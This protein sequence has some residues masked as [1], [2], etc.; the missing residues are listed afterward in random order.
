MAGK[1]LR[2]LHW[3]FS[4]AK[5]ANIDSVAYIS[6]ERDWVIRRIGEYISRGNLG[7]LQ[8]RIDRNPRCYFNSLIHFGSAHTFSGNADKILKN[9]NK[10]V[11]TVFHGNYGISKEFDNALNRIVS[12][13]DKIDKFIVSNT[14]MQK[15]LN[16]WGVPQEKIALI[17]IGVDLKYFSPAA[18]GQKEE[19]RKKLN[20]PPGAVCI[21]SFQKDGN[22]WGEGFEPKL[23]KGPDIFVKAVK[24][25]SKSFK[26][27]C[28][29]AGPARGYIINGLKA[30]NITYTHKF[31]DNY[32]DIVDFYRSLDLYLITAREE[33]GPK[34]I[35]ECMAT[36]VPFVST[37]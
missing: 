22:G 25:L 3:K 16:S 30:A 1:C 21:G 4:G 26:V 34:A 37:R 17:P 36:G 13:R 10:I 33:G 14:I 24:E 29:L 2:F 19:L 35:L 11:L 32:L 27:H 23:V 18:S 8:Y 5:K 6:E 15:R 20:I 28:L 12:S 31:L 9:H 7:G